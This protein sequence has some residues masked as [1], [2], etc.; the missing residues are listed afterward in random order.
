[1]SWVMEKEYR[2]S[3]LTSCPSSSIHPAKSARSP[4]WAVRVTVSP[5]K[6]LPLP[7]TVPRSGSEDWAR[8][9]KYTG[10]RRGR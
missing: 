4:G 1:M 5:T 10:A 8:Q 7:V 9:V 3:W 6:Y 2:D